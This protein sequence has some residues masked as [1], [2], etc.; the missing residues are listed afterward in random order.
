MCQ[1][2]DAD[3]PV[4]LEHWHYDIFLL[5]V[6]GLLFPGIPATFTLDAMGKVDSMEV[7]GYPR[8]EGSF[9]RVP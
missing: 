8:F 6:R 4:D 2:A 3:R 1:T 9:K 7:Q 5:T